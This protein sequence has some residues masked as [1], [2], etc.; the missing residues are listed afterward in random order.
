MFNSTL[1]IGGNASEHANAMR[2]NNIDFCLI[3]E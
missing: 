2:I 3:K 1:H